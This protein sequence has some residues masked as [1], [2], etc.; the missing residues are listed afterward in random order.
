[1][2]GTFGRLIAGLVL[3]AILGGVGVSIYQAG[4]VAGAATSGATVVAP[5]AGYGWGWG[6]GH[7]FGF[8]GSLLALFIVLGLIRAV[9]GGGRRGW[10]GHGGWGHRGYG[11]TGDVS[12]RE[13]GWDAFRGSPFEARAREVHDAW[14]SG[15]NA[16]GTGGTAEPG[17][18]TTPEA[19]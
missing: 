12:T 10:H 7:G 19:G 2:F 6:F 1:M 3:V 4:F 11:P 15:Q 8:L 14:H 9:V 17:T 13:H 16:P 5:W 18:K